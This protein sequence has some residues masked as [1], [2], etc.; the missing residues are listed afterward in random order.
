MK[1]IIALL[2]TMV[3]TASCCAGALATET[4]GPVLIMPRPET[5]TPEL[6]PA[7]E[8]E[9]PLYSSW[10][11]QYL[12]DAKD[13]YEILVPE[14]IDCDYRES[15]TRA[16]FCVLLYETISYIREIDSRYNHK[17]AQPMPEGEEDPF[18]DMSDSRVNALYVAGIVQGVGSGLFSSDAPLTRQE[19]ATFLARS[20]AY[21]GLQT[22]SWETEF[23]DE[24]AIASW[25]AEAVDT[26]CGMGVMNGMGNG[27][28]FPQ[29]VYTREQAIA[30]AVRLIASYPYMNNRSK[31]GKELVFRFNDMNLWLEDGEGQVVMH[32]PAYWATYNYRTDHGYR[33][34]Q[35]FDHGETIIMAAEGLDTRGSDSW[36]GTQLFDVNTKELLLTLPLEAG[37]VYRLTEDGHIV[38]RDSRYRTN[39]VD[40]AYTVW[41]VYDFAGNAILPLGCTRA[42][43]KAAG[44]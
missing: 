1:R 30:T 29:G 26:V 13:T 28:F 25:A 17:K 37:H 20:A 21:C 35:F 44:Y 14:L 34:A 6:P 11:E 12:A 4:T 19:A 36:E 15:I 23:S 22:F 38:T 32:L 18:T 2:L 10:A 31:V 7:E 43:L 42:E 39:N 41:G 5:D 3:M 40:S 33:G 8:M 24:A 9:A 16:E 27:A